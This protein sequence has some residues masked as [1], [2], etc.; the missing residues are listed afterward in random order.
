M[1]IWCACMG[2]TSV[3]ERNPELKAPRT[4][5][6]N[7]AIVQ[8]ML[9]LL[10]RTPSAPFKRSSQSSGASTPLPSSGSYRGRNDAF[11]TASSQSCKL[12]RAFDVCFSACLLLLATPLLA[13]I[14]LVIKIED[15]G[16][17]LYRHRRI[18]KRGCAFDCLKFRTMHTDADKHLQTILKQDPEARQEWG[19]IFKLKNDPRI[20]RFG[21]VLRRTSLDELPQFINVLRNDMSVVGPR[22]VTKEELRDYYGQLAHVYCSQKPGITGPWQI[23]DRHDIQ[24][25]QERVQQDVEYI[26]SRSFFLDLRIVARTVLRLLNGHGAC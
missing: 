4:R 26:L 17:I 13:V 9:I 24:S 18:G 10:L 6:K 11:P 20:T 3:P 15:R 25:Y 19:R 1:L 23:G 16:P 21:K 14:A 5:L 22:P 7:Q 2:R 8:A 12:K